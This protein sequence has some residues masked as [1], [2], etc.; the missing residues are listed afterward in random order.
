M[1]LTRY[2]LGFSIT[3]AP[4]LV[5]ADTTEV[6][7]KLAN[8][9]SDSGLLGSLSVWSTIVIALAT[10]GMVWV[11]GYKMRG[12][13]FGKVFTHFALGMSLIFLGFVAEIPTL[14]KMSPTVLQIIHSS[15]FVM[16]FVLM[17]YGAN[18]LLHVV[19]GR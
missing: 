2:L 9:E 17:G 4:W 6:V 8:F 11:G 19:E 7:E 13:I 1:K 14:E 15:L 18:K 10:T 3:L 5:L 12:G 16:G